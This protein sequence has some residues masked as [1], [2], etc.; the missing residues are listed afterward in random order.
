MSGW[1]KA[2]RKIRDSRIWNS[3]EPFDKR[4]AWMDLLLR[5][6]HKSTA[7]P[8]GYRWRFLEAGQVLTSQ[9]QLA[10]DWRWSRSTVRRYLE[11]LET[12]DM[13]TTD[14][15]RTIAKGATL[16][17]ISNWEEYQGQPNMSDPVMFQDANYFRPTKWRGQP[18][19]N[20]GDPG[21]PVPRNGPREAHERPATGHIQEEQES[22]TLLDIKLREGEGSEEPIDYLEEAQRRG[23]LNVPAEELQEL[24]AQ[25]SGLLE[26]YNT[27][28][29]DSRTITPKLMSSYAHV[30]AHWDG[31]AFRALD[32]VRG[33]LCEPDGWAI[34][35]GFA[36]DYVFQSVENAERYAFFGK[37]LWETSQAKAT[38]DRELKRREL[39]KEGQHGRNR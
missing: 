34:K 9:R 39:R 13:I 8:Q 7:L 3:R 25:L 4:S 27:V 28:Q 16:I 2:W 23:G 32:A 33:L 29:R 15:D 37:D 1:L 35:R 10:E 36:L 19:D 11:M 21:D 24:R 18:L 17:T 26:V 22:T 5:A 14:T 30:L 31:D 20:T 6:A 12:D 38:Y